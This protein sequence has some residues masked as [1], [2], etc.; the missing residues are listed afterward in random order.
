MVIIKKSV[1]INLIN[2]IKSVKMSD[3]VHKIIKKNK[4]KVNN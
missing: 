4:K 3:E 2:K 1:R